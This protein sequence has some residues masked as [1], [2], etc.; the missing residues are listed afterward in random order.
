L[1]GSQVDGPVATYET[2]QSFSGQPGDHDGVSAS[3]GEM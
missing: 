1:R 3:A 2:G